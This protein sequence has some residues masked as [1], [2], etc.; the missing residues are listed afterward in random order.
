MSPF[1]GFHLVVVPAGPGFEACPWVSADTR[2]ALIDWWN[3]R[4][5]PPGLRAV[6]LE[7]RDGLPVGREEIQTC[8]PTESTTPASGS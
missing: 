6:I 5:K 8:P 2:Q 4:D 1:T 3:E 7:Y